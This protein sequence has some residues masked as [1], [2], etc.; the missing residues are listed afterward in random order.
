VVP[1][2]RHWGRHRLQ[3]RQ[4]LCQEFQ[5]RTLPG[6]AEARN[7]P[8]G[9]ECDRESGFQELGDDLARL[10]VVLLYDAKPAPICRERLPSRDKQRLTAAANI[11]TTPLVFVRVHTDRSCDSDYIAAGHCRTTIPA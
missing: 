5:E 9:F 7:G 3:R 8:A 2:A 6:D 11:L 4:T 10:Q 1:T